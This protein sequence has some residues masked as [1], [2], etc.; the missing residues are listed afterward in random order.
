MEDLYK[1]VL[2]PFTREDEGNLTFVHNSLISFLVERTCSKLP[3]ANQAAEERD[4]YSQ[5]AD[6]SG[7]QPCSD[8]LGRAH[9]HYL[10]RANRGREVL[11]VV[12][13]AWL[14]ESVRAFVPYVVVSPIVL[15]ALGFA[16]RLQECGHVVRLVLLDFELQQRSG[17]S[18]AEQLADAFLDLGEHEL[19]LA[20][21]QANGRLLVKD[22][23]VLSFSRRLWFYSRFPTRPALQEVARK[24]YS[25]AKPIGNLLSGNPVRLGVAEHEP[26]DTVRSWC[27]AAP[28]FEPVQGVIDQIRNLEITVEPQ[29]GEVEVRDLKASLLLASLR[30]AVHAKLGASAEEPLLHAIVDMKRPDCE[31]VARLLCA[32]H[33]ETSVSTTS[34]LDALDGCGNRGD[35]ALDVAEHLYSKGDQNSSKAIVESVDDADFYPHANSEMGNDAIAVSLLASLTCLRE[36]LGLGPIQERTVESDGDEALARV[37]LAAQ[38]LGVLRGKAARGEIPNDLR[39]QF[40]DV[41]LYETVSVKRAKYDP[42]FGHSVIGSRRAMFDELLNV[43]DAF[44]HKG[45]DALRD[46]VVEV[47]RASPRRLGIH[48]RHFALAF[49]EAG[50]LARSDA[51]EL[52]LTCVGDAEEDDPMLRQ[53]ACLDIAGCLKRLAADNWREWFN[54]AGLASAGAG[55]HK[56]YQMEHIAVWLE[57]AFADGPITE[58]RIEVLEKFTRA[59]EVAGGAGQADA[60]TDVLGFVLRTVPSYAAPLAVEMVDRG[61]IGLAEAVEALVAGGARGGVSSELLSATFEELLS[62]VAA[63]SV[64]QVAASIVEAAPRDRRSQVAD[65]IMSHVRTNCLPST[66]IEVARDIQDALARSGFGIVDLARGLPASADDASRSHSLYKLSDTSA[67][68]AEQVA[69]K[70]R[71]VGERDEWDPNPAGNADFDW[72]GAIR[73][74]GP[75]DID[76]LDAVLK[77]CRT[78]DY[79]RGQELASRSTALAMSGRLVEARKSA[80]DALEAAADPVSWFAGYDGGQRRAAFRAL[81]GLDRKEAVKR[82]RKA[83][84][85]DLA[86]G[87]LQQ[88]FLMREL[89]ELFDFLEIS[90]PGEDVLDIIDEYLDEVL[91]ATEPVNPYRSLHSNETSVSSDEAIIRFLAE[92]FAFPAVDIACAARRAFASYL[93]RSTSPFLGALVADSGWSDTEL[94]YILASID[95]A[96]EKNR[97]LLCESLR[98]SV[99]ALNRHESLGVRNIARRICARARWE[100]DEVRDEEPKPRL[101]IAPDL[102]GWSLNESEMLV[103]GDVVGMWQLFS[104]KILVLDDY[105]VSR[106]D[107]QSEFEILYSKI[108]RNY[109]WSDEQ[110]VRSWTRLLADET[111]RPRALIGRTAAMRLLGR[112]A[113]EGV[114]SAAAEESYD[115]LHPLYD[116]AIELTEAA[117]RPVELHALDWDFMDEQEQEWVDG[118]GADDWDSYPQ[119]IGNLYVI[120]EV[121]YFTRLDRK[122]FHERRVRGVLNRD[123][124]KDIGG[125]EDDALLVGGR[126]LTYHLYRHGFGMFSGEIVAR[127]GQGLLA[128]P[129]YRW[130]AL[131]SGVAKQLGWKPSP[132]DP[133]GWVGPKLEPVVS[134]VFWRDGGIGMMSRRWEAL[135]AGWCLLATEAAM[136]AIRHVVEG[137]TV[138]LLVDRER[139]GGKAFKRLWH[140]RRDL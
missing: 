15:E 26:V 72:W 65:D 135:G 59:L 31:L 42:H 95:T 139:K 120:G 104:P 40:R 90:W 82:S 76:R 4:Y 73:K 118:I 115:L 108:G 86:S 102:D 128:G 71:T 112:Y 69:V 93:A 12:T 20:Q 30:T 36:K 97:K 63:D 23:A 57:R 126:D 133:F 5:L 53:E 13:S 116:P 46:V 123:A 1:R 33:G 16:W 34:L 84:G 105:G 25:D 113:L 2:T 7:G 138:H 122:K 129:L 106:D 54:R 125:S 70:L 131:N 66:R 64:G 85:D 45:M 91:R 137:A 8:A 9:V 98:R 50:V 14:R 38:R 67:L 11:E 99:Q 21:L 49:H 140:L 24:L 44:R 121:S 94:E 27:S 10:A 124:S 114:G 51:I 77:H 37:A 75:L 6:R 87:T 134:G 58:R 92:L 22:D 88:F 47:V 41:L 111:L 80:E 29:E 35:L 48:C 18:D 52:A 62:L 32:R 130:L 60:A 109:R 56:D 79:R 83:F 119:Q 101:Y 19:A 103:R 74:A 81:A 96:S 117:E 110:R 68:T 89:V 100:W 127:N 132:T 78:P 136:Q 43:A 28:L 39:K 17:H 55:N 3:G 107:L 61:L